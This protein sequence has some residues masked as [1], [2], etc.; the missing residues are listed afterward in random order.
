M[1]RKVGQTTVELMRGDIT[2]MDTDA[3]VNAANE[4]LAHGGG[5]AG[6]VMRKGGRI[7]QEESNAWVRAHGPV[8]TGSA[9][10]TSGGMLKARY[11]IHAVGPVFGVGDEERKLR[12]AT[13]ASLRLADAHGLASIS[14]P[15]ISTGI[16][17]CPMELCAEAMLGAVRDYLRTPTSLRRIVFC[18]WS[19]EAMTAFSAQ[20]TALWPEADSEGERPH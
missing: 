5:V 17:G 8:P 12:D 6:A 4:H 15:A 13:L 11:V 9:A 18:L 3:I 1:I 16:F 2:E 19:K 20:L 7:I 14:F 10:I